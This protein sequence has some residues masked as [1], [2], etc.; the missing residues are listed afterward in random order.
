VAN[1]TSRQVAARAG[2]SDASVYYHFSDRPGLLQAVFAHGLPPLD[3]LVADPPDP[4]LDPAVLVRV[5]LD[6][7]E[8]FFDELLPIMA[9]AQ[10]DPELRSAMADH[11]ETHDLGPHRGVSTLADYLRREQGAGQVDQSVDPEAMAL[12]IIDTAF[13]RASRRQM[14]SHRS[15]DPRMPS[16]ERSERILLA[17]LRPPHA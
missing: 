11:I 2:V 9:A 14:L 13:S 17:A 7:L 12:L 10:S 5:A 8:R 16:R 15:D 4:V 1:L 3:F 6:S